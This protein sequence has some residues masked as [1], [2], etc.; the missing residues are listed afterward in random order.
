MFLAI[1][2]WFHYG[3]PR[4]PIPIE[5]ACL[6]MKI[7]VP[8]P[9]NAFISVSFDIRLAISCSQND[10][11]KVSAFFVCVLRKAR[12]EKTSIMENQLLDFIIEHSHSQPL[13]QRCWCLPLPHPTRLP[14]NSFCR[15][16]NG[17]AQSL[18]GAAVGPAHKQP[19]VKERPLVRHSANG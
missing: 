12:R 16:I 18:V 17:P 11:S 6:M 5:S 13:A 2:V 14:G 8:F 1:H 19:T 10:V 4:K 9:Y 7:L 3:N 15:A